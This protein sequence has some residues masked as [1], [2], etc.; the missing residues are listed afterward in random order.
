VFLFFWGCGIYRDLTIIEH[1][2]NRQF[3]SKDATIIVQD[4]DWFSRRI[5]FYVNIGTF[6]KPKPLPKDSLNLLHKM[7]IGVITFSGDSINRKDFN[8]FLGIDAEYM[9][10]FFEEIAGESMGR[11]PQRFLKNFYL[12]VSGLNEHDVV[13]LA[14]TISSEDMVIRDAKN[15]TFI[16]S[17]LLYYILRV[18]RSKNISLG[19]FE[20]ITDNNN[21]HFIP[22]KDS[23]H[24]YQSIT[25]INCSP[26]DEVIKIVKE[27]RTDELIFFSS[28]LES[29]DFY[30]ELSAHKFEYAKSVIARGISSIIQTDN[31]VDVSGYSFSLKLP[32]G[33]S[34]PKDVLSLDNKVSNGE[35]DQ[36]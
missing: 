9:S 15:K 20:I 34:C 24:C 18:N 36:N 1:L 10:F 31:S 7:R 28:T 11:V 29:E 17:G 16:S 21:T 32:Q 2:K 8:D 30:T 19:G 33:Y 5:C 14:E 6:D 27:I 3:N 35:I 4:Y 23:K 26:L 22:E 13:S 25:L 12:K